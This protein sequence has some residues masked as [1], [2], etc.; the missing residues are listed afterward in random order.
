MAI[1]V[2]V[3]ISVAGGP[4]LRDYHSVS[5][6][7]ELF[8]HHS[9]QV[10]VPY[11]ILETERS[12]G[13]FHQAHQNYCGK[14]VT[15]TVTPVLTK[16]PP[17]L[18]KGIVTHIALSNSGDFAH[19]FVLSGFSP[20]Y[21]LEDGTQRRTFQKKG[22]KDIFTEVLKPYGKNVI[23]YGT[24]TPQH[25][26]QVKYTVQYGES[27]YTFLR[28]LADE[29]GEWFYY[30][31]QTLRLGQPTDQDKLTFTVTG[32]EGFAMAIELLPTK[33]ALS[34]YDYLAHMPYKGTSESQ[35]LSQLNPFADFALTQSN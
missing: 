2:T 32:T 3:S 9:F 1:A 21:L 15:I 30:D 14:P 27:T 19:S 34:R 23:T 18:F 13:F 10:A 16:D 11:E 12:D 20:T 29:Y 5:I 25:Q 4:P 8:G 6:R 22:L 26:D 35:T 31:G 17:L 24:L 7:Q 33:F 28:R